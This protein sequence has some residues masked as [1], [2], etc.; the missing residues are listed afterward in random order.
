MTSTC[1]DC[2]LIIES[3]VAAILHYE[4][5]A[6]NHGAYLSPCERR[7]AAHRTIRRPQG[8]AA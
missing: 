3:P 7:Q 1:P 6:N 4:S 5:G 8:G 2:G